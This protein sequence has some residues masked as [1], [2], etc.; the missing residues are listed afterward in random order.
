VDAGAEEMSGFSYQAVDVIEE[1]A[2][3]MEICRIDPGHDGS[4]TFEIEQVGLLCF[5]PAREGRRVLLSLKR[6]ALRPMAADL[7][8]FWALSQWEPYLEVPINAGMSADGGL[9]LLANFDDRSL[10]LQA[11]EQCV[12]R[13]AGLHDGWVAGSA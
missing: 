6:I 7:M 1:F 12:D 2:R 9:V 4:F 3:N 13:L 10:T 11:V 8:R 5:T